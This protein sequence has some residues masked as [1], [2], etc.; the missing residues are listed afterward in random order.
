MFFI[1]NLQCL[2]LALL[3]HFNLIITAAAQIPVPDSCC[4]LHAYNTYTENG[5]G[6]L[7][8]VGQYLSRS[9]PKSHPSNINQ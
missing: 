6:W 4:R 9:E 3:K 1:N 2:L 5:A 8:L 7:N